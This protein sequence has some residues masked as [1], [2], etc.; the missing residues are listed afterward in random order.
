MADPDRTVNLNNYSPI[1][2]PQDSPQASSKSS[3][4]S[5]SEDDTSRTIRLLESKLKQTKALRNKI[6]K[7]KRKKKPIS[8]CV[9]SKPNTVETQTALSVPTGYNV[10][11]RIIPADS[12]SVKECRYCH[13]VGHT[14]EVC[15]KRK[16]H[17]TTPQF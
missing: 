17:N 6:D 12:R 10:E 16:R 5:S 13:M 14:I 4:D 7:K 15:R 11:Y 1:P 9:S 2:S 8:I 3:S